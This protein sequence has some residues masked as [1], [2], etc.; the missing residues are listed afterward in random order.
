MTLE[1]VATTL[2]SNVKLHSIVPVSKSA[3]LTLKTNANVSLVLEV[4]KPAAGA[5]RFTAA[6]TELALSKNTRIAKTRTRNLEDAE[7]NPPEK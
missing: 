4:H 2:L 5:S 6:R 3:A 1:F 7:A